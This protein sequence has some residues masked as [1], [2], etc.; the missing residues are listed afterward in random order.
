MFW[1]KKK[2]PSGFN[3]V[4]VNGYYGIVC[5]NFKNSYNVGTIFRTAQNFGA[6]FIATIG[7]EY[8]RQPGDVNNALK[9]IPYFFFNDFKSFLGTIPR[10]CCLVG[11]EQTKKSANLKKFVHPK[12]A[13]YLFG[14]ELT[15]IQD[16][17]LKSC[18]KI[19]QIDTVS[20]LNIAVTSGIIMYDRS[21]KPLM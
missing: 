16:N 9:H 7:Q 15:G 3:V 20:S 14:N 19:V 8:I 12:R 2:R 6:D 1:I 18:N 5:L 10:N 13:I 11:I 4:N 17:Y 21:I